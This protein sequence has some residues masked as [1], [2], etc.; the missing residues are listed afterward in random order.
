MS[1]V[2]K[3]REAIKEEPKAEPSQ[4]IIYCI[5]CGGII[6]VKDMCYVG[7]LHT[8]CRKVGKKEPEAGDPHLK[9]WPKDAVYHYC[10]EGRIRHYPA[11]LCS[12]CMGKGRDEKACDI[13]DRQA[14][15]I[16]R[17][18]EV[19]KILLP[20]RYKGWVFTSQEAEDKAHL[21]QMQAWL[22]EHNEN[23]KRRTIILTYYSG[24]INILEQALKEK[25]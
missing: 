21:E 6:C 3:I 10:K 9:V 19:L 4:K 24:A 5:V 13:I 15:E 8:R 12:M 7:V 22:D 16:E 14:A 18:K 23:P 1:Q 11:L 25:S 2:E 20:P 17:L